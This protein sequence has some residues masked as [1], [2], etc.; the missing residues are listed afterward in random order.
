[1]LAF[2]ACKEERNLPVQQPPQ[3]HYVQVSSTDGALIQKQLSWIA[4]GLAGIADQSSTTKTRIHDLVEVTDFYTESNE[5]L[6]DDLQ[7][8]FGYD[9]DNEVDQWLQQ[10]QP[11]NDYD[12]AYFFDI[13]IDD[14]PGKVGVLIPEADIADQTQLHVVTLNNPLDPQAINPGY[15][16]SSTTGTL[17]SMDITEDN[18]NSVYLWIVGVDN[19]CTQTIDSC[20]DGVIGLTEDCETCPEDCTPPYPD[21]DIVQPAFKL[22]LKELKTFTD[23]KNGAG[24]PLDQYQEHF[25]QAK[26]EIYFSYGVYDA[27]NGETFDG[28]WDEIFWFTDPGTGKQKPKASNKSKE[29]G[30]YSAWGRNAK[31]RRKN[32]ANGKVNRGTHYVDVVNMVMADTIQPH[33]DNFFFCIFEK[34]KNAGVLGARNDNAIWSN[35]WSYSYEGGQN[36][37]ILPA[38]LPYGWDGTDNWRIVNFTLDASGDPGL[39]FIPAGPNEWLYFSNLGTEAEAIFKLERI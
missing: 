2:Y 36:S 35:S 1:M 8:A 28:S 11:G 10:N 17:D 26:Y 9:Y 32:L 25:L 24:H 3:D 7:T 31:I 20:G 4:K 18:M 19:D 34:D 23:K 37:A 21:F 6:D 14:C 22:S 30:K 16:I 27:I 29:I 13:D 33:K 12:A 15:F 5:N 39:P 38:D